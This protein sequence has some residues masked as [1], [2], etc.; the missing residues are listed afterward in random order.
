MDKVKFKPSKEQTGVFNFITKSD[1]NAVVNAVAGSGKT[2]TLIEA[3]KLIE[4]G[5]SILF[6]A[7]NKT[8]KQEIQQRVIALNMINIDVDTCHGFEIGRASCRERV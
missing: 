1:G 4:A 6:L 3:V 7:F 5:K 8:I 2:T